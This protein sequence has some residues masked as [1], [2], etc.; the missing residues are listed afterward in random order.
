MT[1]AIPPQQCGATHLMIS[2]ASRLIINSLIIYR[3]PDEA[4]LSEIGAARE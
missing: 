2:S 4:A 1:T 3:G